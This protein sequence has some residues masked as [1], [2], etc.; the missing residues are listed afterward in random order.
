MTL[1]SRSARR[2]SSIVCELAGGHGRERRVLA[3]GGEQPRVVG[4]AGA[5][6]ARLGRPCRPAAG[7]ACPRSSADLQVARL[8]HGVGEVLL[9]PLDA[10]L[11]QRVAGQVDLACQLA[12]SLAGRDLL[13]QRGVRVGEQRLVPASSA[14]RA[15]ARSP[16]PRTRSSSAARRDAR[17]G[18]SAG[19][20]R[21]C[22]RRC[23]RSAAARRPS[24]R[25]DHRRL[26]RA[27]VA[28]RR[29]CQA[30]SGWPTRGPVVPARRSG[31]VPCSENTSG[32]RRRARRVLQ[33]VRRL[34]FGV[35]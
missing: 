21:P 8:L 33:V 13:A 29:S 24:D 23:R 6:P 20:R 31:G 1:T 17:R 30:S 14:R 22:R 5:D 9:A 27:A 25:A 34:A 3:V 15:A 28:G 35:V 10:L 18:S 2:W 4:Q 7:T 32:R 26:L 12:V 11:E 16:R 19:R